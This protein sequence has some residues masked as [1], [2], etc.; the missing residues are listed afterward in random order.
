M[1]YLIFKHGILMTDEVHVDIPGPVADHHHQTEDEEED[2]EVGGLGVG[3]VQQ[4]EHGDQHDDAEGDVQVP[5]D[6]GDQ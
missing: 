2:E 5:G 1:F 4:A 3:S 6:E